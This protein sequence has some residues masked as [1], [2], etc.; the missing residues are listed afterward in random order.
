MTGYANWMKGIGI[1]PNT[2]F[3]NKFTITEEV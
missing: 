1:L 3:V 2:I